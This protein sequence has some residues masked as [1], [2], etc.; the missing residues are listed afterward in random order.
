MGQYATVD[1]FNLEVELIRANGTKGSTI[2]LNLEN[3]TES[4]VIFKVKTT[5]PKRYSV[6]PNSGIIQPARSVSVS[7][8]NASYCLTSAVVLTAKE[9]GIDLSRDKFL[10]QSIVVDNAVED[11][12]KDAVKNAVRLI[13]ARLMRQWEKYSSSKDNVQD[14]K[15]TCRIVHG[16]ATSSDADVSVR[17]VGGRTALQANLI[18]LIPSTLVHV[19]PLARHILPHANP[20][21][22]PRVALAANSCSDVSHDAGQ[23]PRCDCP[24]QH[25][26]C[27]R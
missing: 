12:S 18:A 2:T 5:Q 6:K 23:S 21:R 7:S 11:S 22:A 8:T 10:V 13:G 14:Q 26:A 1:G 15:L 19:R 16:D 4:R 20:A 27:H 3:T 9:D 24:R 17:G 25:Y